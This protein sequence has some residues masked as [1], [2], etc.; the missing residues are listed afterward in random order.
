MQA[1]KIKPG[2]I[3]AIE[4]DDR[5]VRF[6]VESVNTK[7]TKST[8]S[9][10]D[11][12]SEVEGYVVVQDSAK[13]KPITRTLAPEAIL[14]EYKDYTE[15][16]AREAAEKAARKADSDA[17]AALTKRLFDTLYRLSGV[18]QGDPDRYGDYR[19]P[20]R[21]G[22][23]GHDITIQFDAVEPLLKALEAVKQP[24]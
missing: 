4:Q 19:G 18:D 20:I 9:P 10:H 16:V 6:R 23:A 5:L 15:L 3:Y 24:A 1:S 14:G 17:K 8:G 12:T 2:F 11:Y 22:Y 13:G 7:R 21:L